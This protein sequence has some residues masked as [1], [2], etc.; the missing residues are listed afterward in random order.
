MALRSFE[1]IP[2]R[3][4][5]DC[6]P[7]C[8]VSVLDFVCAVP[9]DLRRFLGLV[10]CQDLAIRRTFSRESEADC[11]LHIFT[12]SVD[13]PAS[14]SL[15][16]VLVVHPLRSTAPVYNCVLFWSCSVQKR[17]CVSGSVWHKIALF[18]LV[19]S[20]V[21]SCCAVQRT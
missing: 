9:H 11:M 10:D 17:V 7:W 18:Y 21:G 1:L 6:V 19:L 12:W 4:S 3:S 13:S 14:L 16:R 5:V 2:S 8:L 15:V 20:L